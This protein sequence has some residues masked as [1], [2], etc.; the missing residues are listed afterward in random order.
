MLKNSLLKIFKNNMYQEDFNKRYEKYDSQVQEYMI[1]FGDELMKKYGEIPDIF[2]VTLDMIAGNL[3]IMVE[4]MKDIVSK[5][6]GIVG[7]DNYRGDK[8]STQ[9]SAFLTSQ[10]NV[11]HLI[12]KFG[13]TPAAKSRIREN[14]DKADVQKFL[15]ELTK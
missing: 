13:W 12:D 6:V 7:K 15:E 2:L 3:T 9:L 4:A 14:T 8:K 1:I 10:N 11:S 5:N